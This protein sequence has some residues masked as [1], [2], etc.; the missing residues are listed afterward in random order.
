MKINPPPNTKET[1]LRIY[2]SEV[3]ITVHTTHNVFPSEPE[4][5]LVSY[6]PQANK[7]RTPTQQTEGG[8]L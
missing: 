7:E 5:F 8:K 4:D 2:L 1:N 3:D 6:S